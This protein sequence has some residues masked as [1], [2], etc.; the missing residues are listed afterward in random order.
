[1]HTWWFRWLVFAFRWPIFLLIEYI[2]CLIGATVA[3]LILIL[4]DWCIYD[5]WLMYKHGW[6]KTYFNDWKLHMLDWN[7]ATFGQ[8]YKFNAWNLFQLILITVWWRVIKPAMF[9]VAMFILWCNVK[10]IK[11][12]LFYDWI[13]EQF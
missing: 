12:S 8:P 13:I 2:C 7:F 5:V 6:L 9:Y 1:M 10:I 3:W 4:I 11:L